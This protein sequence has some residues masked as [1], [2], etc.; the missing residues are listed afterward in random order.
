MYG[1]R[2]EKIAVGH[3]WDRVNSFLCKFITQTNRNQ[4]VLTDF[5]L[6]DNIPL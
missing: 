6:S 1:Y 4:S 3:Y 2:K 5:A